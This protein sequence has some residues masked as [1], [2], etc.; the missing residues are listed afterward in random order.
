MGAGFRPVEIHHIY[1]LPKGSKGVEQFSH[2]TQAKAMA[3]TSPGAI[4]DSGNS[5]W[6]RL[7]EVSTASGTRS[8]GRPGARTD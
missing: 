3:Q 7:Q 6:A 4:A 5:R 1:Q 8:T 2:R